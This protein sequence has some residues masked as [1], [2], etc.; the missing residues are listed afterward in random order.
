MLAQVYAGQAH[1]QEGGGGQRGDGEADGHLAQ[2]GGPAHVGTQDTEA[3]GGL[4]Q[5]GQHA[6]VE[7]V[8]VKQQGGGHTDDTHDNR[9]ELAQGVGDD[10]Y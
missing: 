10:G 2:D 5:D 1:Q 4:G 9:E 7:G 8:G 6:V 3:L